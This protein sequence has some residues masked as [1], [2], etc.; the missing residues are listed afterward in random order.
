MIVAYL[1]RQKPVANL[2]G[3]RSMSEAKDTS[4]GSSRPQR[5]AVLE[6]SG[7]RQ[8]RESAQALAKPKPYGFDFCGRFRGERSTTV[9]PTP[10]SGIVIYS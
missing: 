2:Q 3:M 4:P 7:L 1:A 8:I 10:I 5:A 6:L 9:P